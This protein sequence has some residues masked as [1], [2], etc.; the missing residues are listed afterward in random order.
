M[1]T[2][3][4]GRFDPFVNYAFLAAN[5]LVFVLFQGMGENEKFTYS[6]STVPREIVTGDDLVTA[7]REVEHPMTGQQ[8]AVPGLQPTPIS[9][10][11]TL[12]TSMFMHGGI[13]HLFGQ[14]AVPLDFRRQCG[15]HARSFALR[16]CSTS[17]AA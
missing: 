13:A 7:D 10:Y 8:V 9:V 11:I 5:V 14:H 16:V 2:T 4:A 17:C 1:T 15:R 3:R 12:L 6:F